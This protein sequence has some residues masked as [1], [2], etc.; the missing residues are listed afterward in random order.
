VPTVRGLRELETAAPQATERPTSWTSR[1]SVIFVGSLVALAGIAFAL[2]LHF[3]AE[4][5]R[6]AATFSDEIR[7]IMPPADTW[8][9]W[10]QFFRG[11]IGR[12]QPKK[13][14]EQMSEQ[15]TYEELKRW[16]II[17]FGVA[18]LGAV[19]AIAGAA[20][21]GPRRPAKPK[22]PPRRPAATP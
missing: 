9:L 6:P 15:K 2:I 7:T 20:L 16:E 22:R 14:E 21:L 13:D 11:G 4:K 5:L 8:T 3:R 19:I 18:G 10:T 12:W 1:H 17:G